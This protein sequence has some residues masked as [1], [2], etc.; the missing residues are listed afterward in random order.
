MLWQV[1]IYPAEGQPDLAGRRL[2]ADAAD[3]GLAD[4]LR[5]TAAH[6]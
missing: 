5:V 4:N 3:L 1:D 6:G 2:A